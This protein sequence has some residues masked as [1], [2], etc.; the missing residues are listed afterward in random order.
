[1]Q[2]FALVPA[3]NEAPRIG[4]VVAG[5]LEQGLP[6]LVVDDGSVDDTGDVA[7]AAG[8]EVVRLEPNRGK[9]AA[10]KAGFEAALQGSRP[11]DAILSLD[12]D[13]QH[14]PAEV[15]QFLKAWEE[16]GADLVVGARDYRDMPPI[17][18]FTNTISRLLFSW[19]LGEK[20]PDNQSGYRLRSRRLVVATLTSA[21]KG[22]AFEV[23]EIAIC[24][25]RGFKLAWV[26]IKTIY[27]TETSHIRPWTHFVSFLRV[28]RRARRRMQLERRRR[29]Q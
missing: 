14:D 27:G 25:G 1:M 16:T 29:M 3:Y 24:V 15:A 4:A 21:E 13:G 12:G 10:L 6:V 2:V 5:L 26:P 20:I 18:W 7:R 22:F 28:T 23:E 17:R 19:A 9:G 8:A 11:W